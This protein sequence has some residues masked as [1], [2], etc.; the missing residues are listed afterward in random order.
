MVERVY[1]V[2]ND[3]EWTGDK[4]FHLIY[5]LKDVPAL[6]VVNW[7]YVGRSRVRVSCVCTL[8]HQLFAVQV[9]AMN[10]LPAFNPWLICGP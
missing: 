4:V 6:Y 10:K 2:N 3:I 5:L 8:A 7:I 1:V 9:A